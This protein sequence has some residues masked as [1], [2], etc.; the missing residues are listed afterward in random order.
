MFTE[1]NKVYE[2]PEQYKAANPVLSFID[3][4]KRLTVMNG[5]YTIDQI[6]KNE[7]WLNL[8]LGHGYVIVE[9][10]AKAKEMAQQ[11]Y[12]RMWS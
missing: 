5:N 1:N 7:F 6:G 11:H 8:S 4:G 9:S 2:S 12:D 10:E 3:T